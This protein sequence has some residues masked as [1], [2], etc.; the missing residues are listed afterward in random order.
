MKQREKILTT[1]LFI[2]CITHCFLCVAARNWVEF[3]YNYS[4]DSHCKN[5]YDSIDMCL[6]TQSLDDAGVKYLIE[7]K[8]VEVDGEEAET[9][10]FMQGID[11]IYIWEAK[12]IWGDSNSLSVN[13]GDFDIRGDTLILY[14]FWAKAGDAP[15]SPY[16]ARI[17]RYGL[18]GNGLISFISGEIYIETMSDYYIYQKRGKEELGYNLGCLFVSKNPNTEKEKTI[19]KKYIQGVEKNYNARFVY[20]D[21]ACSLFGLVR[22]RLSKQLDLYTG[23]WD[24]IYHENGFGFKN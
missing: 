5:T 22:K 8:T 1:I 2:G 4:I 6:N 24:E 13:I 7:R 15:V 19:F 14:N 16:G 3:Q 11:T 20:N 23:K 12:S 9:V 10:Y 17:Q 18:S 21:E